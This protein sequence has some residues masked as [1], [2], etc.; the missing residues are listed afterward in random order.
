VP[1]ITL[2]A[3]QL[4]VTDH[5]G[6]EAGNLWLDSHQMSINGKRSGFTVA[7]LREVAGVAGLK[8][9]RAQAILAEV[10][11]VVASWTEIADEV[12]V[13]WGCSAETAVGQSRPVV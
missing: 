3:S 8:R 4:R 13:D 2:R 5:L 7:D 6:L 11:A 12:G 10:A 1:S 9:G